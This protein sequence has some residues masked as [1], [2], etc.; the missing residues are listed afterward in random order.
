VDHRFGHA[1]LYRL[2]SCDFF[3]HFNTLL[4][5]GATLHIAAG[6][7]WNI[8][9]KNI[10]IP[11][12]MLRQMALSHA[13]VTHPVQDISEYMAFMTQVK[14]IHTLTVTVGLRTP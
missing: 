9:V 1:V 5:I 13:S 3:R 4:I 11:L 7:I 8:L 6:H 14:T 12:N 2:N 10:I